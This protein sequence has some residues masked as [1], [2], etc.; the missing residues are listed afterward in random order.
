MSL[1]KGLWKVNLTKLIRYFFL[2]CFTCLTDK[3][4][5]FPLQVIKRIYQGLWFILH[6]S[7]AGSFRFGSFFFFFW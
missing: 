7:N 6:Q 5:P 3:A 4:T 2:Q 1:N